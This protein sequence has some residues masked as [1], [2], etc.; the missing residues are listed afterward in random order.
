MAITRLN[1]LAIPAD[2]VVAADIADES[3]DEARLQISNAGSNGQFLS[4]QS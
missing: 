4:K 1:S 3:I 2:T